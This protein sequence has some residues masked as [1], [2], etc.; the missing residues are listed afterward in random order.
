MVEWQGRHEEISF[1]RSSSTCRAAGELSEMN[2]SAW[3]PACHSICA[4]PLAS[5]EWHAPQ[6]DDPM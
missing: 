1:A 3:G 5:D 2:A 4:A 6:A